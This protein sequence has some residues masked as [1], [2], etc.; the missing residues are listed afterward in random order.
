MEHKRIL[1]VL[2]VSFLLIAASGVVVAAGKVLFYETTKVSGNYKIEGGYSKFKEELVK[3][4]YSVSRY[5]KPLSRE[6]LNNYDPD[7]LVI[8]NLN[9]PLDANEL[10]AIFEFVMQD[11]KG[12]FICGGTSAA[13]QITIPFGMTID[14]GGT[15]EDETSPVMDFSTGSPV[16]SKTNFVATRI[17]RQNSLVRLVVQGLNQLAFFECNGISISG[18]AMVVVSGD[19]DTYSPKS[20]TFPKGSQ[21][22]LAA[23]SL[24]GRGQVFLLSDADMLLNDK[25]DTVKYRH[26]NLRFGANIVDWLRSAT[27][28]PDESS[29]ITNL[30]VVMGQLITDVDELNKTVQGLTKDKSDLQVIIQ[31]KDT[32]IADLNKENEDLKSQTILGVSYFTWAVA[33]LAVAILFLAINMSKKSKKSGGKQGGAI[34]GFGYEFEEGETGSGFGENVEGFE[35]LMEMGKPKEKT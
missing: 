4:G 12:L 16:T 6:V 18:D 17:D 28:R 31:Q 19:Y 10:A 20:P 24:V 21:P 8:A 23:A 27:S 15:L 7:V 1:F 9:S 30:T 35:D 26:D 33:L 32:A 13:N 5:E 14:E 25:L 2:M 34:S 11:G 22:P 3:K 29:G